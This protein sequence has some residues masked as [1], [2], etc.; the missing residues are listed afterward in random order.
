MA[1]VGKPKVGKAKEGLAEV[2]VMGNA[3]VTRLGL[4]KTLPS[5][6]FYKISSQSKT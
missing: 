6:C 4:D 3:V 2:Q 1:E 5:D